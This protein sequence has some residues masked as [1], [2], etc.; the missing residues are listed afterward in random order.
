VTIIPKPPISNSSDH[1][2]TNAVKYYKLTT[3]WNLCKIERLYCIS[4]FTSHMRILNLCLHGYLLF[5]NYTANAKVI[6]H[7]IILLPNA[8]A[9]SVILDDFRIIH[10][11]S[12]R[13]KRIH[14]KRIVTL[15]ICKIFSWY[16]ELRRICA[17]IY[18]NT[19]R[20]PS[21]FDMS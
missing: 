3:G 4:I 9:K 11:R 6:I 14:V 20:K 7:N 18:F 12:F 1:C 8:N 16:L 17:F 10:D 15:Y 5:C 21:T 19:S 2:L 13:F